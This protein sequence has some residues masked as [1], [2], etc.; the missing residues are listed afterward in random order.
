MLTL[1][2]LLDLSSATHHNVCPRQVLGARMGMCAA[3]VLGLDL[4]QKNKRLFAFMETDGCTLDGVGAA[5]GC[6]VGRRTMRVLDFGKIAVTFVDTHTDRAIRVSP[7]PDVRA[8]VPVYASQV[9][10]RW[11]AYLE[12]YQIMPREK[13]LVVE[14]VK[15]LVSMRE[16]IS[17]EGIKAV[18][19]CCGEEIFNEREVHV[20]GQTL[21]RACA[22]QSYYELAVTGM[23]KNVPVFTVKG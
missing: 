12:A 15:L 5:T 1:E 3:E 10:D 22:G 11:Q 19:E 13:L 17:Q 23:E 8:A 14:P 20:D 18:C 2:E 16:I 6:W 9:E 21:C 7:H 4:P